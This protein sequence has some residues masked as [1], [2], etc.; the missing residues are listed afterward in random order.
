MTMNCSNFDNLEIRVGF[1]TDLL[2]SGIKH[3]VGFY[4]FNPPHLCVTGASGS[5]KTYSLILILQMFLRNGFEVYMADFKG[6]DFRWLDGCGHFF[7]HM[8]VGLALDRVMNIM[9]ARMSGKEKISHPVCLIMD[10]W[11]G[12][13]SMLSKKDVDA[14]KQKLQALLML[15]R[16]AGVMCVLSMQRMDVSSNFSAGSRENIGNILCLGSFSKEAKQMIAPDYKDLLI[17]KGRGKG[18]LVTDG[19][20]PVPITIPRIRDVDEMKRRIRYCMD[21]EDKRFSIKA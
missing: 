18:Y 11:S 10:E 9:N 17:P 19:K 1:R 21:I 7:Q 8:T 15:A 20:V 4:P 12:Y 14:T 2:E 16:G 5:G 6:I 3:A 13:L